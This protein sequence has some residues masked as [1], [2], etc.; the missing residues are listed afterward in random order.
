M[1]ASCTFPSAICKHQT[2]VPCQLNCFHHRMRHRAVDKGGTV[3]R[4]SLLNCLI[5]TVVRIYNL[6]MAGSLFSCASFGNWVPLVSNAN[7]TNFISSGTFAV[8]PFTST[9][10]IWRQKA[11]YHL[12]CATITSE[13]LRTCLNNYI[14]DTCVSVIDS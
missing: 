1:L 4:C 6:S 10:Q 2:H 7:R 12:S 14:K 13:V 11:V 8:A 5:L 3:Q 9:L